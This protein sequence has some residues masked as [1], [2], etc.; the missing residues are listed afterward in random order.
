MD[1]DR[2]NYRA[3]SNRHSRIAPKRDQNA[4]RHAPGKPERGKAIRFS[5]NR[6]AQPCRDEISDADRNGEPDR[7][8]PTPHRVGASFVVNF[9]SKI[10]QHMPPKIVDLAG[11]MPIV[12]V[13]WMT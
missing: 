5:E 7:S 13:V 4:G 3:A 10:L 9:L 11:C 2:R 6:E 8:N 12:P 1:Q